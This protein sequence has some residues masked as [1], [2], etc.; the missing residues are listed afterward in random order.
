MVG[1]ALGCISG[2]HAVTCRKLLCFSF[3][4]LNF[5][6]SH[7]RGAQQLES[8]QEMKMTLEEQLKKKLL[9]KIETFFVSDL[10]KKK[11]KNNLQNRDFPG[12]F[13]G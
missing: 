8:L 9:L 2:S 3:S 7:I 1:A 4:L 5:T 10:L 6:V 12:E 11:K 13:S